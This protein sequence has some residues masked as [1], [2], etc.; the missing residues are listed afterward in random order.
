MI[1][2]STFYFLLPAYVRGLLSVVHQTGF[3][4]LIFITTT[5]CS[6]TRRDGRNDSRVVITGKDTASSILT[7]DL[8]IG[9][10]QIIPLLGIFTKRELHFATLSLNTNRM[11]WLG[12]LHLMFYVFCSHFFI[13]RLLWIFH[14]WLSS[15]LESIAFHYHFLSSFPVSIF[16]IQLQITVLTIRKQLE[17]L[18][19]YSTCWY[20]TN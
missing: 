20:S 19:T 5:R 9:T 2:T 18:F 1:A 14:F 6:G 13:I 12:L 15:V 17:P 11:I 10:V 16:Q 8:Q 7:T 4:G 3:S